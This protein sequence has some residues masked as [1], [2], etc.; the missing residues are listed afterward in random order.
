M[1]ETSNKTDCRSYPP[2]KLLTYTQELKAEKDEKD[3]RHCKRLGFCECDL[4]YYC[5]VFLYDRHAMDGRKLI[6]CVTSELRPD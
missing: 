6:R 5:F 1:Q 2:G 4:A 3:E